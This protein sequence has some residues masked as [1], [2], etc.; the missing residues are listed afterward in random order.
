MVLNHDL[1]YSIHFLWIEPNYDKTC[2][3]PTRRIL[4]QVSQRCL[5]SNADAHSSASKR[6]IT[7]LKCNVSSWECLYFEKICHMPRQDKQTLLYFKYTCPYMGM[8]LF[9]LLY[10]VSYES[11]YC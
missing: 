9:V 5:F 3:I 4:A 2:F 11:P 10:D 6:L 8:V 1:K 7:Y